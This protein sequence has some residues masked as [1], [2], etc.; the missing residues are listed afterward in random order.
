MKRTLIVA[1]TVFIALTACKD[2]DEMERERI[3]QAERVPVTPRTEPE[4]PYDV[5]RTE[6]DREEM[7]RQRALEQAPAVGERKPETDVGEGDEKI[8][9]EKSIAEKTPTEMT[10]AAAHLPKDCKA[11]AHADVSQLME[12]PGAK[13]HLLPAFRESKG[14][15]EVN[16]TMAVMKDAGIDAKNIDAIA[17]CAKELPT[18]QPVR[19]AEKEIRENTRVVMVMTGD[20]PKDQL[21]PALSKRGGGESI[22]IEDMSVF[23]DKGRNLFVGQTDDGTAIAASDRE[24]FEQTLSGGGD[25]GLPTK[26]AFSIVL[27]ASTMQEVLGR[28]GDPAAKRLAAEV[29]R[30]MLTFDNTKKELTLSMDMPDHTQAAELG[31]VFKA[32]QEQWKAKAPEDAQEKR[33][34]EILKEATIAYDD[35]VV[36]VTIAVKDDQIEAIMKN[37][38]D[39]VRASF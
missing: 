32:V 28:F 4:I 26:D 5:P 3:R 19:G 31:G 2:R 18:R 34:A 24:G 33:L 29:E 7:E 21:V 37:L 20:F 11:V 23:H 38:G 36:K 15:P 10:K 12:L 25:Y 35:D 6:G 22:E 9:G 16:A 1:S 13:E 8:A 27:P 30:S 14:H 17:L 39:Q